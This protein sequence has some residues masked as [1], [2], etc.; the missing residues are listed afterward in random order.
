MLYIVVPA[1]LRAQWLQNGEGVPSPLF[2][3]GRWYKMRLLSCFA[4][5]SGQ[6]DMGAGYYMLTLV[7]H[8]QSNSI[9][10]DISSYEARLNM[11][12]LPDI[13]F[14]AVDLLH[15][16]QDYAAVTVATR[17]KLLVA[18]SMFVRKLPIHYHTFFYN[19]SEVKNKR[20][21]QERMRKD[22]SDFV[23]A[24]LSEFQS[25]EKVPIYYDGGHEAVTSA[26]HEAFDAALSSNV[27]I[28]KDLSH[29]EKRLAQAADYL[30]TVEL[31]AAR[32]SSGTAS[33]TYDRFFRG[34]AY[35]KRNYL[36]KLQNK[37]IP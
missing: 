37:L 25:F 3:L 20:D 36:R 6:Q 11:E 22:I 14:H 1:R 21:L 8:D 31:I 24:H 29:Q 26:L 16:H 19:A 7:L 28:Y 35:F 30:C 9:D 32:Y 18:F 34:E 2:I 4:D 15:G 23:S 13:P 27:A 17:K 10:N 33:K 12:N 5:E